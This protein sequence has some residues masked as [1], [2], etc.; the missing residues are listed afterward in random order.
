MDGARLMN[1]VVASGVPAAEW[2]R[3]LRHRLDRLHQGPRR[4]G[5]RR[6]GRLARADRR[7]VALQ[8]DAR[9]RA[10]PGGHRRRGRAVRARPPRRAA[11]RGPRATPA[12]WPRRPGAIPGVEIDPGEVETNIVD[13]PRLRRAR[14][15]AP[16]SRP[17][18][19]IMGALD[20][21][22][23]RAVTHLDVGRRRTSRPRS[24]SSARRSRPPDMRQLTSLDAQF[25]AVETA[26]TYGHVGG[27][28]VYD[29]S[30]A[31]GRRR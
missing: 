1:A 6:A 22:T 7:G 14:A 27:L 20:A 21:R 24:T 2:T 5:G 4:A 10:A 29:P 30:T 31:P 11:R 9:R 18:A 19:S 23:V 8:A 17:T 3:G 15:R 28:A 12:R 25:L 26:R 16:S 13:L